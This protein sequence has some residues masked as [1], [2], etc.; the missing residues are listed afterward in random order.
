MLM[1]VEKKEQLKRGIRYRDTSRGLI[2]GWV[3]PLAGEDLRMGGV[4]GHRVGVWGTG[5]RA[6]SLLTPP[7]L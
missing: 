3:S 7:A 4:S 6:T 2:C 5:V 1:D